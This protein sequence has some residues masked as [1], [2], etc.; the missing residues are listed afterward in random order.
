MD[1]YIDHLYNFPPFFIKNV[2]AT[3]TPSNDASEKCKNIIVITY[4]PTNFFEPTK[5]W[6]YKNKTLLLE[7][8]ELFSP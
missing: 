5:V 4:S 7:L 3:V 6:R 8:P 1:F 2:V